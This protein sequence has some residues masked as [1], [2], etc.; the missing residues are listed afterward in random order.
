VGAA[1]G[2]FDH[3]TRRALSPLGRALADYASG[4]RDAVLQVHVPGFPS[5]PLPAAYFFRTP[6]EMGVVDRTALE[7]ARGRV[8]DV[9]AGAG[10]HAVPLVEAGLSVTALEVLPELV[11][12]LRARGVHGAF[13]RS[14]WTFT[15]RR[16]YGTVLALMNGTSLAGTLS[17]LGPLL[18]RLSGLV[19]PD[20]Q[21]LIDST[22]TE[23][24]EL[25][26]QLEY[27][28]VKGPPFPQLFLSED[29]LRRVA[30][31]AAWSTAVVAREG[32]RYLARLTRL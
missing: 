2:P 5:E 12:I 18:E 29:A 22:E 21:L 19:S 25:E 10:A 31:K 27:R 26:Y 4:A 32:P 13:K 24:A 17:R 1:R 3:L 16:P 15:R 23:P 8:L 20:G 28:G 11:E 6:A 7:L 30:R 14:V 9:G